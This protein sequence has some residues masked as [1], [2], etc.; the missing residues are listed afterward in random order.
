MASSRG[1]WGVLRSTR[2][3]RQS[4][5]SAFIHLGRMA[6]RQVG[7]VGTACPRSGVI[8][9]RWNKKRRTLRSVVANHWA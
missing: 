4:T 8:A 3:L 7:T 1:P 6:K 2:R 5:S 9:P